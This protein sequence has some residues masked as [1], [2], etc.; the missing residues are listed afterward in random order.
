MGQTMLDRDYAETGRLEAPGQAGTSSGVGSPSATGWMWTW[1]IIGILVVLVVIAF[2]LGIVSALTSID[3]ALAEADAA[4]AS[5]EGDVEGQPDPQALEEAGIEPI[6]DPQPLPQNIEN[7][8]SNLTAIDGELAAVPGQADD[9]IA[10]LTEISG[11]L[12]NVDGSLAG[13]SGTL[14]GTDSSLVDTSGMLQDTQGI[15]TSIRTSLET[16][17]S[18][19]DNLGT[20]DIWQRVDVANGVLSS[21]KGDTGNIIV[22]LQETDGHLQSIC[23][24]LLGPC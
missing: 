23:R 14:Q 20:V 19:A 22:E 15:A 11:T 12:T 18:N 21:A 5:I 7:I 10:A 8:N 2:L 13:T 17:Q 6:N 1:V 3:D 4:V 16:T 24:R 9:I